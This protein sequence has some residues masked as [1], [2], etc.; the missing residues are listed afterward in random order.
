M[1]N[2]HDIFKEAAEA[3]PENEFDFYK[4]LQ[5]AFA[6]IVLLSFLLHLATRQPHFSDLPLLWRLL[7]AQLPFALGGTGGALLGLRGD[8]RQYGWRKV[9]NL[10]VALPR[11]KKALLIELLKWTPILLLVG[12]LLNYLS[13]S[14]LTA[15][16]IEQLPKQFLENIDLQA[17]FSFWL[18]AF[19]MAVILAPIHEEILFRRILYQGVKSLRLPKPALGT[20]LVFALA[21]GLP[22]AFLSYVFI[23]LA[24][25]KKCSKGSLWQAIALHA[26][27]N[28]LAFTTIITIKIT[29]ENLF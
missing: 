23:S 20:A 27:Y 4:A 26:C 3:Q 21:H 6:G 16:G 13:T 18:V 11:R 9:L 17:G 14:L 29:T 28:C 25:Q 5:F 12:A 22:Q 1:V 2:W 8:L 10:P 15:L 7:L 24:L 19:I